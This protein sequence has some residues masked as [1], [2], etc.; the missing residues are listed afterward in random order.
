MKRKIIGGILIGCFVLLV[1]GLPL[2]SKIYYPDDIPIDCSNYNEVRDYKISQEKKALKNKIKKLSRKVNIPYNLY[3]KTHP[4]LQDESVAAL[5]CQEAPG[6]DITPD[7]I[8]RDDLGKIR[9]LTISWNNNTCDTIEDIRLCPNLLEL[10]IDMGCE[11]NISELERQLKSILPHL[12]KLKI[13][14]LFATDA[15][16][17]DSIDFVKDCTQLEDI[18]I[19][20][21]NT[22]DYSVLSTC[23]SAQYLVLDGKNVSKDNLHCETNTTEESEDEEN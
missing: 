10:R 4:K 11:K 8:T 7:N 6:T 21:C 19:S 1:A 13:L 12:S 22:T 3:M 14:S 9:S 17:W 15:S 5:L 20:G 18:Y 23:S 2:L 16:D